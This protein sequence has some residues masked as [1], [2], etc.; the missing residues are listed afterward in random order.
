ML[1]AWAVNVSQTALWSEPFNV[2][3]LIGFG[4]TT[5]LFTG[6]GTYSLDAFLPMRPA[7]S[8]SLSS[9]LLR[10]AAVAVV[11]AWV[12]LCGVNPIHFTPR[13]G[14]LLPA[15]RFSTLP[16]GKNCHRFPNRGSKIP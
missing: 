14:D 13:N 11:A 3:F 16:A 15:G 10:V 1:C 9:A 12:A 7:C 6:P 5:Q 2:G 4:A 8:K